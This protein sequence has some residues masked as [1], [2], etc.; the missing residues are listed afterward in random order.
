MALLGTFANGETVVRDARELRVKETD[1]IAG[2]VDN[3]RAVGADIEALDDGAA[4][5]SRSGPAPMRP[6]YEPLTTGAR[7]LTPPARA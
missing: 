7:I 2:V 6:G 5:R 4:P 3:L 1:R